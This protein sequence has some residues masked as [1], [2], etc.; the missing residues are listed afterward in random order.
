MQKIK[1][2]IDMVKKPFRKR[3]NKQKNNN[4]HKIVILMIYEKTQL[5]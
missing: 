1:N 5:V 3:F 2:K 4:L